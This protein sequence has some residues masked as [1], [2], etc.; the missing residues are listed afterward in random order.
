LKIAGLSSREKEGGR[1]GR[2]SN[3]Q[4]RRVASASEKKGG[5]KNST[6]VVAGLYSARG[7]GREGKSGQKVTRVL[8]KRERFSFTFLWMER[9][10]GKTLARRYSFVKKEGKGAEGDFPGRSRPMG[11]EAEKEGK[12]G[13]SLPGQHVGMGPLLHSACNWNRIPQ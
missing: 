3:C 2:V 13:E 1:E 5:W 11:K 12:E 9:K 10:R 7:K 8:K 6:E 4:F